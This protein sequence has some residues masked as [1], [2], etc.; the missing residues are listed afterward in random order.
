M[1]STTIWSSRTHEDREDGMSGE[2]LDVWFEDQLVG[3]IERRSN[4]VLDIGFHYDQSWIDSR[5]S[6]PISTTMPLSLK[7]HEPSVVYPWFLNLLP[8]GRAL[9]MI[10]PINLLPPILD[11]LLT[12]FPLTD[13]LGAPLT[14]PKP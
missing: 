8:E 7:D 9:N 2:K 5:S 12:S 11:D 10:V 1:K 14:P 3:H 4:S 13:T 6:F